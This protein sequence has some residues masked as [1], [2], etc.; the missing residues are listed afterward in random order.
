MNAYIVGGVRTATAKFGGALA[1]FS[2]VDLGSMVIKE[3]LGRTAIKADEVDE[4]I[5][6]NVI[7]AGLGQ[8]PAR[9]ASVRGGLP[10]AV[11]A[12]TVNKVCGS[13]LKTVALA[14]QA[15]AA[16]EANMIIAGGMEHMSNAPYFLKT[17]RWGQRLGDGVLHDAMITDALWDNF[18]DYH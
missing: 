1:S 18:Y 14:G 8:N 7:Q 13:G 12:F 16:G 6:G 15:I 2:A 9:Q 4:V 17:A 10:H 5:M 11:P 3:L